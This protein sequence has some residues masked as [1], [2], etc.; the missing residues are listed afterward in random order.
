MYSV[1]IARA[2]EKSVILIVNAQARRI[3]R[4]AMEKNT[5]PVT[6]PVATAVQLVLKNAAGAAVQER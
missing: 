1:I 3:V 6:G 2:K 4:N 5:L